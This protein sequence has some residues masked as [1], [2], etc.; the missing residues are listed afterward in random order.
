M[1]ALWCPLGGGGVLF[2]IMVLV[3]LLDPPPSPIWIK[4]KEKNACCPNSI[5]LGR[6]ETLGMNK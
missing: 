2:P 6:L 1:I 3:L 4:E 5:D